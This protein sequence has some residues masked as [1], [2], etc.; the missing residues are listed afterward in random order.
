MR[1]PPILV[2][3]DD[4]AIAS[5]VAGFLG[6]R[7]YDVTVALEGGEALER[8]RKGDYP[9]I[10]S[11]IYIDQV[12]GLDVLR[13]ARAHNRSAAVIL[14]TVRGSVRT[15]VEAEMAWRRSAEINGSC[16]G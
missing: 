8:I 7:G 9:I 16:A 12:S 14:M 10:I 5:T 11:D 3:D 1:K 4:E 15:T 13:A 6:A 2:I